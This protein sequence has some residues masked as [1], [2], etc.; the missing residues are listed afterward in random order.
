[1]ARLP[2]RLMVCAAAVLGLCTLAAAQQSPPAGAPV[3]PRTESVPGTPNSK[4]PAVKPSEAPVTGGEQSLVGLDVFS[5]EGT[6]VGEVRAVSTDAGGDVVALH[7]RTGGFLGFGGRTVA[8][9]KGRFTRTGHTV[10]L[11]LGS[12]QVNS[13]P[14]VKE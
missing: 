1:M 4:A 8:V 13:L 6:R 3:A 10:R 9:P 14:E 11:D 2:I 7:V 5:S 12:D